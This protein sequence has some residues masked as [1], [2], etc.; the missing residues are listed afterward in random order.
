MNKSGKMSGSRRRRGYDVPAQRDDRRS[1]RTREA[2]IHALLELIGVKHY[3]Q[4]T[5]QD[6][7]DRANVG[8]ST[9]YA[10][11]Q[12]KDDLLHS[13]F[14]HVLDELVR[15]IEL[16][17]GNRLVFDTTFLFRHASE[18]YAIYRTLIWGSGL[19]VLT[20]DGHA[21]LS[22][23]IEERFAV[24]SLESCSP[25]VPLSTIAY[26]TAGALLLLL[27]GW[28]DDGMPH[29]PEYMDGVFQQLI[30]PGVSGTLRA[31]EDA[32]PTGG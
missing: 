19:E 8:R 18:H 24:L 3:D 30:M 26:T 6:I 32:H 10:H 15:H 20:K 25:T 22:R 31:A 7:V 29:P 9:F 2:L 21:A 16:G 5:V 12:H 27:K 13:G 23:K 14:D 4:I 28:L 11:Y 17:E 1:E